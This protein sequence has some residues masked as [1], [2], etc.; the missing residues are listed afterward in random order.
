MELGGRGG[1]A[2]QFGDLDE[3]AHLAKV[4][5]RHAGRSGSVAHIRSPQDRLVEG[6]P[7]PCLP[8][9]AIDPK[10]GSVSGDPTRPMS[11]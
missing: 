6:N 9:T 11:G 8:L 7:D 2:T 4:R 3:V 5:S 10:I 1:E